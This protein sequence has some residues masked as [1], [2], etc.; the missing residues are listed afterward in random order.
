MTEQTRRYWIMLI[1]AVGLLVGAI[2]VYFV[3]QHYAQDDEPS[4]PEPTPQV[5]TDPA[6]PN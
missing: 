6:S 4:Q 1:R 3:W 5:Q 2:I